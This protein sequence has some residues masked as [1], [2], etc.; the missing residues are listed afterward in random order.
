MDPA[1]KRLVRR[2]SVRSLAQTKC[3]RKSETA[4]SQLALMAWIRRH[5]HPGVQHKKSHLQD[6]ARAKREGQKSDPQPEPMAH[7]A[8][9][10]ALT[11]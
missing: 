1:L 5:P 10:D 2:P 4:R 9:L 7:T 3:T 8:G 6:S 11:V